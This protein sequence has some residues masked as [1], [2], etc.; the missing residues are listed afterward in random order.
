MDSQRQPR[1]WFRRIAMRIFKLAK[2]FK[3]LEIL[4]AFLVVLVGVGTWGY[5][6][7]GSWETTLDWLRGERLLIRPSAISLGE[8]CRGEEREVMLQVV[9]CTAKDIWLVGGGSSCGCL[10]LNRFPVCI[11]AKGRQELTIKIRVI[12]KTAEFYQLVQYYT[13]D[14]ERPILIVPIRGH[15]RDEKGVKTCPRWTGYGFADQRRCNDGPSGALVVRS[16]LGIGAA[17]SHIYC[18]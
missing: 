17:R 7:F 3:S 6:E 2:G 8:V 11:P 16:G 10:T 4:L 1:D 15:I 12:S 14:E 18:Q 5:Y 13:D 9:N